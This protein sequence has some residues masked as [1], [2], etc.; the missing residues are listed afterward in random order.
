MPPAQRAAERGAPAAVGED[1]AEDAEDEEGRDALVLLGQLAAACTA[2]AGQA[3]AEAVVRAAA[4]AHRR[5][6]RFTCGLAEYS[7]VKCRLTGP[8]SL[9]KF[10]REILAHGK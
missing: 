1:E 7:F 9:G 6:R 8:V 3:R 10:F 4:A 2:A 5:A